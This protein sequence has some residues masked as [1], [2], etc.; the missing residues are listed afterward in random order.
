MLREILS[1]LSFDIHRIACLR[2]VSVNFKFSSILSQTAKWNFPVLVVFSKMWL[3]NK[4]ELRMKKQFAKSTRTALLFGF[5]DRL[6]LDF[7]IISLCSFLFYVY[8]VIVK[9]WNCIPIWSNF[10][11]LYNPE[12]KR[13]I[14]S[15]TFWYDFFP[16]SGEKQNKNRRNWPMIKD[17]LKL[18]IFYRYMTI[19]KSVF[20]ILH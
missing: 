17:I 8:T 1:G 12:I 3:V 20:R 14:P 11:I 15:L 16:S 13:S 5:W 10:I 4:T 19:Y 6:L 9:Q 18:K 2:G 7:L